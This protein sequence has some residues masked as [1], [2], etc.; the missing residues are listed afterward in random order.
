MQYFKK[1]REEDRAQEAQ[2]NP[3]LNEADNYL[4]NNS[5]PNNNS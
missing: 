5:M 2:N 4:N 1:R 3:Q